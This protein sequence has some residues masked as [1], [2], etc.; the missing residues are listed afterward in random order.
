LYEGLQAGCLDGCDQGPR[1]TIQAH[2][3][4]LPERVFEDLGVLGDEGGDVVE[5]MQVRI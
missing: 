5:I 1:G 3:Q 4:V 2:G